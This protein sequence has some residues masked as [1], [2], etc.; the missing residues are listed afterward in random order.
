MQD[1]QDE[2]FLCWGS[3]DDP[4]ALIEQFSRTSSLWPA[5]GTLRSTQTV[6]SLGYSN[7]V[8]PGP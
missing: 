1:S 8:F 4:V 2:D 6:A 3:I 7:Q 5:S